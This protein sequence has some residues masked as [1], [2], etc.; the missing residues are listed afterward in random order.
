MPFFILNHSRIGVL[1]QDISQMNDNFEAVAEQL[2]AYRAV[3]K[4]KGWVAI[5]LDKSLYG[6]METYKRAFTFFKIILYAINN[7]T[8]KT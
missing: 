7:R 3:I 4:E 1:T 6:T 5:T 8:R 2:N